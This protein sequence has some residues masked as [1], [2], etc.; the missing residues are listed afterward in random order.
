MFQKITKLTFTLLFSFSIFLHVQNVNAESVIKVDKA[1]QVMSINSND[2]DYWLTAPRDFTSM[3]IKSNHDISL[4]VFFEPNQPEEK[5][6]EFEEGYSDIVFVNPTNKFLLHSQNKDFDYSNLKLTV[7]FFDTRTKG[8]TKNLTAGPTELNGLRI[9]SRSEWGADENL[10]YYEPEESDNTGSSGSS[11]VSK[12]VAACNAKVKAYPDEYKYAK[13]LDTENGNTL[14]WPLQYSSQIKKIVVHHTGETNI[15]NG[16]PSDEMV[17]AIYYYHTIV[18][19]WGDIGYHYVIGKDGEIFEGKAGGDKVVGAHVY[20]NNIGTVGVSVMGNFQ[21]DKPSTKQIN[22]LKATIAKLATKYNLNVEQYTSFHGESIP[23]LVGHRDLGAT[24]CPGTNLYSL[25]PQI[26]KEVASGFTYKFTES[27]SSEKDYDAEINKR[28]EVINLDPTHTK[29]VTFTFKNTG[30]E[31]WQENTWLHVSLNKNNN[32]WADSVVP[33]KNF[34]AADMEENSVKPGNMATFKVTLNAGYNPGFY[35]LEFAPVVNNKYKISKSAIMQ[36]IQIAEP[37]YNYTFVKAKHPPTP[38]YAEQSEEA[39]VDLKNTGNI[40][41]RNYGENKI[42][43]GTAGPQDRQSLFSNDGRKTRLGYLEEREIRPGETGHFILPLTAPNRRGI[44]K[45]G[46]AP[47][48]EGIKWLEDKGMNFRIIVKEPVHKLEFSKTERTVTYD[49][50]EERSLTINYENK[51]D[52]SWEKDEIYFKLGGDYQEL[53]ITDNTILLDE[54]ISKGKS[55]SVKLDFK[56]PFKRGLYKISVIPVIR[57]NKLSEMSPV[58]IQVFVNTPNATGEIVTKIPTPLRI[59]QNE[60]QI[61]TLKVKNTSNFTWEQKGKYGTMLI[62]LSP[63]SRLYVS[64]KWLSKTIVSYMQE[65]SVKPGGTATF[66]LYIQPKYRGNYNETFKVRISNIGY[67]E[68]IITPLKIIVNTAE[69]SSSTS[70]NVVRKTTITQEK[71]TTQPASNLVADQKITT[72]KIEEKNHTDLIRV[73]LSVPQMQTYELTSDQNFTIKNSSEQVLFYVGKKQKVYVSKIGTALSVT[74]GNQ[75]KTSTSYMRLEND[76]NGI[77]EIA[78]WNHAPG[79]NASLNDN[80]FRGDLELRVLDNQIN[81]I[82]E[83][84]LE[85]YLKGIAEVSNGDPKEKLKTMAVLSRSYALFYLQDENEKFPGKPYDASDDPNV[86]Q[87][88]LGYGLEKRSPNFTQAIAETQGEVVT[89]QGELIKTPYFNQS[90]GKTLSAE[91]VW[92]WTHTP[93]LISVDDPYCQGL[94]RKGHGVGLSGYGATQMAK[95]GKDYKTIIK[96]YYKDVDVLKI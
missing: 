85:D 14:K 22:S 32:A 41:W 50:G 89:Y 33:D 45:E 26:R 13:T 56:T 59:N 78:N 68:G 62:P 16:R 49:P 39:W 60:L 46:F 4:S 92:G 86:F 24:A 35:I 94:V 28:V 73:K 27:S 82:N 9:I 71:I 44:F 42:Y 65:E 30:K 19:G 61:K 38:F 88:Y 76:L 34:V 37:D 52:V 47:V 3:A 51:S 53:G 75:T 87:K 57:G 7:Y 96:Y 91:E 2:L 90:D 66:K 64:G 5:E 1:F 40:I 81:V 95:S 36:P 83:V 77:A 93:Y 6:L 23:N 31:I 55:G 29:E 48:I 80:L 58:T 84:P 63:K 20:C 10:R 74:L 43:L 21:N 54:A 70:S 79:W 8:P 18:K 72:E 15:V 12:T 11:G 25:L 17:R 67:V 69:T